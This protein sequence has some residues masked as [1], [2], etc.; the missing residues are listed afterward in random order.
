MLRLRAA[1]PAAALTLAAGCAP[2]PGGNEPPPLETE[3]VAAPTDAALS[4]ADDERGV[5][6]RAVGLS[7]VLPGDFP[8]GM[9]LPEPVSVIDFAAGAEGRY[10]VLDSPRAVAE[11][12]RSWTA[13]LEAAGWKVAPAG[14]AGRWRVSRG[15]AASAIEITDTGAGSRI[16]VDYSASASAGG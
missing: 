1:V 7:G 10:V 16:R 9:P 8:A 15:G 2:P 5:R 11:L 6:R 13:R 14:G 3:E 4:V 12:A